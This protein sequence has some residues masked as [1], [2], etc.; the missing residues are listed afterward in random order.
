MKKRISIM[1]LIIA[2]NASAASADQD[3]QKQ[4]HQN[5]TNQLASITAKLNDLYSK[6]SDLS[7]GLNPFITLINKNNAKK[8]D[9]SIVPPMP[10]TMS[11]QDLST[12]PALPTPVTPVS[13][14][15]AQITA[16]L[17]EQQVDMVPAPSTEVNQTTVPDVTTI[18]PA[19]TDTTQEITP[20]TTQYQ[21]VDQTLIPV[22]SSGLGAPAEVVQP[23]IDQP[24]DTNA[25]VS[26]PVASV[27]QT[28]PVV[29][30]TQQAVPTPTPAV[31]QVI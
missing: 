7:D 22:D 26:A 18:I 11:T 19:P 28:Q 25:S 5:I 13:I 8:N 1:L 23:Q 21:P 6:M 12:P 27:D 16:V 3:T 24:V 9:F 29:D 17:P 10:I 30:Q 15:P 14:E 2:S 31:A 4:E 20:D